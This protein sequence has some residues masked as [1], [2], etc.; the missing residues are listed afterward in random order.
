MKLMKIDNFKTE[1]IHS[2]KCECIFK[3]ANG[4][5]ARIFNRLEMEP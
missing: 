4:V 1:Y 3:A 5:E 2:L